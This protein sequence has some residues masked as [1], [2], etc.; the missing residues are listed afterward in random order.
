MESVLESWSVGEL[1]R[2]K[3]SEGEAGGAASGAASS[4]A[5]DGAS[6]GAANDAAGDGAAGDTT[7]QRE[8]RR[9]AKR[10][11]RETATRRHPPWRRVREGRKPCRR[12]NSP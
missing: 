8:R 9:P 2:W 3:D 4:A 5:G 6:G 1:E 10:G 12:G 7:A 11:R